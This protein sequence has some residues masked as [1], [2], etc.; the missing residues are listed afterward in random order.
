MIFR[1]KPWFGR[2]LKGGFEK[3]R[4]TKSFDKCPFENRGI[5]PSEVEYF[6]NILSC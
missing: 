4:W 6:I 3:L 2:R 1:V 5:I